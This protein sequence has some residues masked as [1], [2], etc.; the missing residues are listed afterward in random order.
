MSQWDLEE[1]KREAD[2][3]AIHACIV[4]RVVTYMAHEGIHRLKR[5]VL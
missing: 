3:G 2:S 5:T 4:G 1:R